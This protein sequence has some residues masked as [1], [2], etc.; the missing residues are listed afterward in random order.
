MVAGHLSFTR[1]AGAL[2]YAQSSVTAQIQALETE[3]G[4]SLFDRL[5]RRVVLTGAGQR[6]LDYAERLLSLA[7]EARTAVA[8]GAEPGGT[9]TVGAPE[10]VLT[11]RLPRVLQRFRARYARVHLVF[12]PT[13]NAEL[14]RAL[15]DGTLDVGFGLGE[16]QRPHGLAVE[17]LFAESLAVVVPPDHPLAEAATV[18]PTDLQSETLLLTRPGCG[19]RALFT[20]TLTASGVQTAGSLD[21]G[22]VEAIK[23][24]VEAGLGI[25]ALPSIAVAAELADRRLVGLNWAGPPLEVATQMLW[26]PARAGGA[27]LRAFLEVARVSGAD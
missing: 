5:G 23:Q 16:P 25:A 27:A 24:C 14:Q 18:L 20:A 2:G 10:S 7:D 8:D 15:G 21:F 13:P 6:L 17:H 19:Y 4:V 9:L 3:L 26:H 11:Y 1:A 12:R 22:S